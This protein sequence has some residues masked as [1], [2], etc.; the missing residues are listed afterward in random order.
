MAPSRSYVSTSFDGEARGSCRRQRAVFLMS[1][2]DE[3]KEVISEVSVM[4]FVR[5]DCEVDGRGRAETLNLE[6]VP[7]KINATGIKE[8]AIESF[9]DELTK[10][11]KGDAVMA[12]LNASLC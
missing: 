5:G 12:Q 9:C 6:L 4:S 11:A 2:I 1:W 8:R 10:V 7:D 3:R